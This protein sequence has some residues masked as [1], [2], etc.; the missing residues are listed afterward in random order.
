[1]SGSEEAASS[2]DSFMNL[3]DAKHRLDGLH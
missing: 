2:Q 1:V 3:H